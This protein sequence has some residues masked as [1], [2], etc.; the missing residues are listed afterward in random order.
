MVGNI[1]VDIEAGHQQVVN[2]LQQRVTDQPGGFGGLAH[3][4]LHHRGA[5][6]VAKNSQGR[7]GVAAVAIPD[8]LEVQRCHVGTGQLGQLGGL[9]LQELALPLRV[10]APLHQ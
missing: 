1:A 5:V 2:P 4:P 3:Q 9:G 10:I 8:E 6:V 7:V